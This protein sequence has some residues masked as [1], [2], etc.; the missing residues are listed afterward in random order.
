[1]ARLLLT[2]SFVYRAALLNVRR[3]A[4]RGKV[5]SEIGR[6]SSLGKAETPSYFDL[7]VFIL[8]KLFT[9]YRVWSRTSAVMALN[10]NNMTGTIVPEIS[11]LT[12]LGTCRCY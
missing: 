9:M 7:F 1:M 6:M 2:L 12:N 8:C 10:T 3:N 11:L 4:L 5:P